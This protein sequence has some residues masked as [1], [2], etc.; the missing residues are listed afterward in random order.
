MKILYIG[1]PKTYRLY[2]EGKILPTG[3][4]V[5]WKWKKTGI[6]LSG[7]RNGLLFSMIIG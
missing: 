1:T 6:R 2:K 4:M 3:C 7:N 5:Q